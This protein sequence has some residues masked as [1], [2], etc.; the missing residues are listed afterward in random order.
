MKTTR[1][2][3]R[4]REITHLLKDTMLDRGDLNIAADQKWASGSQH[5]NPSV[6]SN[7]PLGLKAKAK[8]HR[9]TKSVGEI[10]GDF[11]IS[12]DQKLGYNYL[13]SD[14]EIKKSLRE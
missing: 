1:E 10:C 7:K 2:G 12:P 6:E 9:I 4:D 8:G 5:E 3:A 14:S 11:K 13:G